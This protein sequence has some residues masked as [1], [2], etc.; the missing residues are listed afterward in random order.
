MERSVYH[1]AVFTRKP[2][3]YR[4]FTAWYKCPFRRRS[5]MPEPVVRRREE[6]ADIF[7]VGWDDRLLAKGLAEVIMI[8]D[9]DVSEIVWLVDMVRSAA[10][11]GCSLGSLEKSF[12]VYR[13]MTRIPNE[14]FPLMVERGYTP[15]YETCARPFIPIGP[16]MGATG[17]SEP[18][19]ESSPAASANVSESES[20]PPPVKRSRLPD[21]V[22][23]R[24][25]YKRLSM[26][27]SM[28]RT[29][30]V[31]YPFGP[32]PSMEEMEISTES[33]VF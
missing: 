23:R 1:R 9:G 3:E 11:F 33:L 32:S 13:D 19:A 24:A 30:T 14:L 2:D 17:P 29:K 18:V 8:C 5:V 31:W 27:A 10:Y 15:H 28:L 20:E 25:I 22:Y 4:A 7:T 26:E 21:D 12:I 16:P 6:N